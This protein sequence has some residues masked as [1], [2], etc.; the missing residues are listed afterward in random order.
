V[1]NR[2]WFAFCSS[3]LLLLLTACGSASNADSGTNTS[4]GTQTNGPVSI[5]TDHSVYGP[6]EPIQ[7]TVLDKLST[8]IYALDTKAGCS[9]LD[10]EV[11]VNGTWQATSAAR[12]PLGRPAM[13]VRIDAGKA[14]TTTIQAGSPSVF[15]AGTYRLLL[16]YS[17]TASGTSIL[18]N[19]T[20]VY[21]MPFSVTG[22]GSP[23]SG[24]PTQPRVAPP[25]PSS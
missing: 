9:I 13:V 15:P 22:S 6:S 7:V 18:S 2:F 14:Y 1:V 10:L 24:S 8:P 25:P 5:A 21:S 3:S 11:Q 19:P 16:N 23:G 12:C 4:S 17:I 20:T